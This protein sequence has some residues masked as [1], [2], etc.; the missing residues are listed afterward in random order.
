MKSFLKSFLWLPAVIGIVVYFQVLQ[1][2][3]AW[4]DDQ[5]VIGPYA[6]DFNL[7]LK[8][9]YQNLP[10]LHFIPLYFFQ[11]FLINHLFGTNAFPFGFHLYQL[12]LHVISCILATLVLFKI[13]NN[14]FMSIAIVSLWT[15]HPLNVEVLTRL[16]C[17]PAQVAAGT[18]C[19][20][21]T[22]CFLKIRE[23]SNNTSKLILSILGILFFLASLTSYEQYFFFPLILLLIFLYLDGKKIFQEKSY[24]YFCIL[25]ILLVD[26][27]Y[28]LWKYF[29]CGGTLFETSD[30]LIKWTEMGSI[31]DILFRAFWLSPQL[32]IHYLRLFFY[33][34]YL[35]ES[36][37]DWFKVGSSTLDTYSIFCQA[38]T[39]ILILSTFFLYKKMPLFSIGIIWF[40]TSMVLVVQVIPLFSMV[41]E[42]YCYLSMLGIFLSIFSLVIQYWKFI[43]PRILITITLLLFVLLTWRTLLYIPSGKNHTSNLVAMVKYSPD[44]NRIFYMAA[45][46]ETIKSTDETPLSLVSDKA[47]AVEVDKWYKKY[48]YVKP[49]LSYKFGPMQ[50][51]Y[52]YLIYKDLC[53]YLYDAGRLEDLN[54]L[55]KQALS[56]KDNAFGWYQN[57]QF[58]VELKQWKEAWLSLKRTIKLDPRFK[59]SY[60][61]MF[62]EIVLNSNKFYEAEQLVKNYI[63]LKPNLSH[64]YL[65]A[66]LFYHANKDL[67]KALKYFNQGIAADK[68]PS[69]SNDG[70]YFFAATLFIK[71]KMFNEAE[72]ALNIIVTSI[73]PFN[74][75]VINKLLDLKRLKN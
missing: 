14:R 63:E 25:P 54:I 65:F 67:E 42:H 69:I 7:M 23:V 2:D 36:Q 61:L 31:K 6:K 8:G 3:F 26:F 29:A 37:A 5:I 48:L 55:L 32:I 72:K 24:L 20:A 71:N 70:L 33:P 30:E 1:F 39:M 13:T 28:L 34:N 62:I 60:D 18:F 9:F 43:S 11:S 40:L 38:I 35:A 73:D 22:F 49:D 50:V 19:L 47:Y 46:R 57:T 66:G 21:F 52:N 58:L 74:N 27:L 17:G 68:T 45:L 53:L 41:D 59:P 16:G 56:I 44:W 15:V 4:G 12:L 10:G 75:K 64:P 51:Y